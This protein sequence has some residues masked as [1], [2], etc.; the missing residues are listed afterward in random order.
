M[1]KYL[2]G[3]LVLLFGFG[4]INN[5]QVFAVTGT[6]TCFF[7]Q[8]G[9][10]S[11]AYSL[12]NSNYVSFVRSDADASSGV[13]GWKSVS[14]TPGQAWFTSPPLDSS[15]TAT[16]S[17]TTTNNGGLTNSSFNNTPEPLAKTDV[18]LSRSELFQFNK[19]TLTIQKDGVPVTSCS[20]QFTLIPPTQAP[21]PGTPPPTYPTS[22]A[23]GKITFIKKLIQGNIKIDVRPTDIMN[24]VAIKDKFIA[25]A[26]CSSGANLGYDNLWIASENGSSVTGRNS[27]QDAALGVWPKPGAMGLISVSGILPD[28]A[29]TGDSFIHERR[30]VGEDSGH[31]GTGIVTPIDPKTGFPDYTKTTGTDNS[32]NR[33]VLY[34][35][36]GTT[37]LISSVGPEEDASN[38]YSV[39]LTALKNKIITKAGKI[40]SL[41]DWDKLGSISTFSGNSEYMVGFGDFAVNLYD[42]QVFK[43]SS[44]SKTLVQTLPGFSTQGFGGSGF[45][46]GYTFD[47]STWPSKLALI[48]WAPNPNWIN[49]GAGTDPTNFYIATIK[50]YSSGANG[51]VLDKTLTVKGQN[52]YAGFGVWGNYVAM[53]GYGD[54]QSNGARIPTLGLWDGRTGT[55]LDEVSMGVDFGNGNG[56]VYSTLFH[57]SISKGGYMAVSTSSGSDNSVY[58]YKLNVTPTSPATPPPVNPTP[59][60]VPPSSSGSCTA[61][62]TFTPTSVVSGGSITESW[63]VDGADVGQAFT[64]CGAGETSISAGPLSQKITL[65]KTLTCR[66]YGKIDGK[67]ACT[68]P[69]A[70]AIVSVTQAQADTLNA[71]NINSTPNSNNQTTHTTYAFG[72]VTLRQGSTGPAVKELQ[73]FLNNN[74]NLGLVLDGK[75]GPKTIA[76]IKIWQA[77]HGLVA[78]GL[79]GPKTKVMMLAE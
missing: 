1:K 18:Q 15:Y 44:N 38:Q 24:L 48:S 64:D 71:S 13:I 74:L 36:S 50:V 58:L 56:K 54:V 28:W 11:T 72:S 10:H 22:G 4:I 45:V 55:K 27:C 35:I 23:A 59:T 42:G 66:V 65:T 30:G 26:E 47:N 43:V 12:P 34:Q 33:A 29:G 79:V 25:D 51:L 41:P 61:T 76:V 73:R 46:S 39:G 57:P 6:P 9:D 2:I 63:K 20:V 19:Y 17:A 16:L 7:D 62:L 67:E 77:N 53:P 5:T 70:T 3:G 69:S 60:F 75:L 21:A 14:V 40:L 78:D 49:N 68:S 8:P 52:S 31:F 37:A 32:I